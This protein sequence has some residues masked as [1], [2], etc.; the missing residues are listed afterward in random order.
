MV[1][2]TTGSSA[3]SKF[4]EALV[5]NSE[6]Y[7]S[8]DFLG[9]SNSIKGEAIDGYISGAN[10]FIDQ[11][12]NFKKDDNEYAA[13]TDNNGG[14]EIDVLGNSYECLLNRPIIADVPVGAAILLLEK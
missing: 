5:E 2:R 9:T 7:S 4:R 8:E 3:S 10:I 13:T 6:G 12:F 11:N 1:S 14:F